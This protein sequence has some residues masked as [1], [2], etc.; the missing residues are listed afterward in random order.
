MAVK[1]IC[2]KS[3]CNRLVDIGHKYCD[4]HKQQ[5]Q[6]D[7]AERN[8]YYDENLR[9]ERSTAF[10]HSREW[11]MVRAVAWSRD[12]GL[13]QDCLEMKI[14]KVGDVVD[15]IVPIRVD[16]SLKLE[17]SNLR[18]LCHACH[19]AKSAEDKKKYGG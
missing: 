3:G 13:C 16:W 12:N 18:V 8:R 10:Y 5:E 11:Q 9:D 19:N 4:S 2:A 14:I 1:K 17:L 15:H 6:K 7:R